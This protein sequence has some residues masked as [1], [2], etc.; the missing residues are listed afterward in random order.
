MASRKGWASLGLLA[1]LVAVPN[2]MAQYYSTPYAPLYP[3]PGYYPPPLEFGGR[4]NASLPTYYGPRQVIC[5]LVGPRPLG[6]R[7]FCPVPLP[8]PG[9]AP[10]PVPIGRVIP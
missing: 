8:P 5:A 7:C 10:G 1:A 6:R 2:A 3:A 9:Y 4:C